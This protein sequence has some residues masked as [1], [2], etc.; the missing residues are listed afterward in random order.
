MGL[1]G[2]DH[3]FKTTDGGKAWAM[4]NTDNLGTTVFRKIRYVTPSYVVASG[5]NGVFATSSDSGNTWEPVTPN[6]NVTGIIDFY[7]F[8]ENNGVAT[9]NGSYNSYI[10]HTTD[11]G[12]T[13]TIHDDDPQDNSLFSFN[14]DPR[15]K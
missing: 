13:F 3:L 15:K 6:P 7:F 14:T 11:G 9:G 5:S 2:T 10:L 12:K 8:D 1:I 4:V